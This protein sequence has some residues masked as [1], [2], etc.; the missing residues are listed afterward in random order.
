MKRILF[1][2]ALAA[3]AAFSAVPAQAA[4]VGVSIGFAAPGDKDA[5]AARPDII[6]EVKRQFAQGSI[7]ALCWHARL[8]RLWH[9]RW[10]A[11][12]PCK[13]CARHLRSLFVIDGI[14][15]DLSLIWLCLARLV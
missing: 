2:T 1:A 11:R 14:S 6:A 8:L 10:V 9:L 7:I 13:G 12:W 3:A 4:Q 5:V 15:G